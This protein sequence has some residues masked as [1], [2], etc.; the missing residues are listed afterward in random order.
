MQRKLAVASEMISFE[1]V[2]GSQ[3]VGLACAAEDK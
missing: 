2:L 3:L 1:L